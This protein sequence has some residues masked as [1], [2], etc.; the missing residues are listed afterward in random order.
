MALAG[1]D[2]AQFLRD[3]WQREPL[4]IQQGL[5][6]Y[7]CPIDG[8]DLAGLACE[9]EVESRLIA[10][11]DKR[12][13]LRNGPMEASVFSE[14]PSTHW[15]LLVQR[16]DQWFEEITALLRHFDFLP[17]WRI[18]DIMASYAVTGGGVGPHFDRYDVFLIQ[19]SGQREWRIGQRCDE[20]D[21]VLDS[22]PLR[23]LD[24]FHEQARYV[25]NPGDILYIP[26]GVAHWGTALDDQC[27]TLSVGFRAP[28]LSQILERWWETLSADLT[29]DLRY[30]DTA[31]TLAS[32]Q[33]LDRRHIDHLQSLLHDALSDKTSLIASFG[34]LVTEADDETLPHPEP[35]AVPAKGVCRSLDSRITLYIDSPFSLLFAN[36]M[37]ME[38]APEAVELLT[39]V[40]QLIPG[41][42]L[43][44]TLWVALQKISPQAASFL[45]S[46]R[47]LTAE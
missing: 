11:K 41:D 22:Q 15:T 19:G 46:T 14:L 1:F 10:G 6:D 34:E 42:L 45:L 36:G 37:S 9:A 30:R 40:C 43:P 18:E 5:P 7:Q 39:D 38:I 24:E 3:Y 47:A 8:D 28:S 35:R 16:V 44:D 4:L 20:S 33:T 32:G 27:I 13:Q 29:E 12:W 23:L 17:Q 31:A 26:P 2:S 21:V 25:L